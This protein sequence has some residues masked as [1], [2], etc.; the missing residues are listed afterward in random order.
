[1]W[2]FLYIY[3]PNKRAWSVK[4]P[5]G[6]TYTRDTFAEAVETAH[7]LSSGMRNHGIKHHRVRVFKTYGKAA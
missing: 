4:H 6:V 5:S 7:A 1:M 3:G 2:N